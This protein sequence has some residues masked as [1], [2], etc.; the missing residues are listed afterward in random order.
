M[1]NKV[2]ETSL[3]KAG[4]SLAFRVTTSDRKALKADESTVF[5]KKVSSDGSQITFSKVEPI[6]PKL[7]KAYMNFAKDNKELLS[8]LRDL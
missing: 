4:N 2:N 6:N 3:F 7:K 5:E 1:Q 8:E